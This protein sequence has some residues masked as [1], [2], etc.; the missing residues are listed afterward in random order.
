MKA[1][2]K[3]YEW[4]KT[5]A[6]I[7][8]RNPNGV[9]HYRK[10]GHEKFQDLVYLSVGRVNASMTEMEFHISGPTATIPFHIELRCFNAGSGIDY[11]IVHKANIGDDNA[12][13]FADEAL[14]GFKVT[15]FRKKG[16]GGGKRVG[17]YLR[18]STSTTEVTKANLQEAVEQKLISVKLAKKVE[19]FKYGST[20]VPKLKKP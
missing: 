3:E 12:T 19:E 7:L 18:N 8:A 14:I 20:R 4:S 6:K 5:A 2:L 13:K 17:H 16:G 15:A 1:K 10:G 9:C 11:E